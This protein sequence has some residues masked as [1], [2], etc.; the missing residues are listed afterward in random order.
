MASQWPSDHNK[1]LFE[2][3]QI[4]LAAG[5]ILLTALA[6]ATTICMSLNSGIRTYPIAI[7]QQSFSISNLTNP[8]LEL[9][10]AVWD[11]ELIFSQN[12]GL[13]VDTKHFQGFVYY[14]KFKALWCASVKPVNV[15]AKRPNALLIRFDMTECG[16]EL[17]FDVLRE[18]NL[19]EVSLEMKMDLL[20]PYQFGKTRIW[21]WLWGLSVGEAC[22]ELRVEF[23]SSFGEGKL[24]GEGGW[25]FV[26]LPEY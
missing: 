23:V 7:N 20:V 18:E 26:P 10:S 5:T 1:A 19:K 3:M 11:A 24:V 15:E 17:V 21:A 13:Q 16:E 12:N 9:E 8:I 14:P 6:F 25:C 22:R 4:K 2:S